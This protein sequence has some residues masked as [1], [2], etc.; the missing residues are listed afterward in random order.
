MV[1]FEVTV[2]AGTLRSTSA[3]TVNFAHRWTDAGVTVEAPFT[4]GHLWVLAPAGC[5]LN[6]LYREARG[7]DVV[8][9]GVRVRAAG[10]LDET[11]WAPTG[12]R[13]SIEVD[14]P[15]ADETVAELLRLVESVAEIPQ[16]MRHGTTVQRE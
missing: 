6:D 1:D 10:G 15:A 13:Y 7:R 9:D 5:L 12:I 16:A 8:V 11:T 3:E 2:A 14:S 4:G